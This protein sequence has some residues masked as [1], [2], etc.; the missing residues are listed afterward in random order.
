MSSDDQRLSP[1]PDRQLLS[2]LKAAPVGIGTVVNRVVQQVNPR[3]C[4]MTG[5]SPDELIG[6]SIR[7]FY[8]SEEEFE[9]VGR[10]KYQE[11][12][13]KGWGAAETRWVRKDGSVM[14]VI[15]SSAMIEPERPEAG[16]TFIVLDVT[17]WK[18][19]EA[20]LRVQNARWRELFYG[21]P[22]GIVLLDNDFRVVFLNA[23]FTRIFGYTEEELLG[24][25]TPSVLFPEDKTEEG[26]EAVEQLRRGEVVRI[27]QTE[28]IAKD[29]RRVPVSIVSKP[30]KLDED[31][32]GVYGI[33][34][35]ITALERAQRV[36]LQSLHEKEVLLQEVHHRVKN[37][38]SIVSSLLAL[39]ASEHPD[40]ELALQ[41]QQARTR[42][43]SMAMLHE[44]VYRAGNLEQLP[45]NLYLEDLVRDARRAYLDSD[46]VSLDLQLEEVGLRLAV[47]I[48][49]GLLVNEIIV[50][51]LQHA[52]PDGRSGTITVELSTGEEGVFLRVADDGVGMQSSAN[53]S[54]GDSCDGANG[55]AAGR[56]SP[57]DVLAS[58]RNGVRG[59]IGLELIRELSAQVGGRLQSRFGPE[60]TSYEL[61]IPL[62]EVERPPAQP[63]EPNG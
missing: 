21:A 19:A 9:R 12:E 16:V 25:A 40:P 20:E 17:D 55:E 39:Q 28:R 54:G 14:D 35:D 31:R 36:L 11:L 30:I 50:N 41:I 57:E 49:C 43:H 7:L 10:E 44:H 47:A 42:V 38:L 32:I 1:P 5:Y 37:N 52:F 63:F 23:E 46:R 51:S 27:E 3:L 61:T 15:V 29:G 53:A 22:E 62:A 48:P 34:R 60:G 26:R 24:V 33:Y 13:L 58:V 45:F 2:I 8:V 4:G 59:G 18:K 6:N 56:Q